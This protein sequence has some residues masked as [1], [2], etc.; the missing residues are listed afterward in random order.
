MIFYKSPMVEEKNNQEFDYYGIKN[1]PFYP[2][3]SPIIKDLEQDDLR[4]IFKKIDENPDNHIPQSNEQE[5]MDHSEVSIN[6]SAERLR[7]SEELQS[8][9]PRAL[10]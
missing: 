3:K 10:R 1:K 8:T 7:L 5:I 6:I 4:Q 9:K 2:E